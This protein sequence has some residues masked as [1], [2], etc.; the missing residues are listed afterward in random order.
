MV[1][2]RYSL[3]MDSQKHSCAYSVPHLSNA[4]DGPVLVPRLVDRL[5]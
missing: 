1:C 4:K 2:G 3:G 5:S